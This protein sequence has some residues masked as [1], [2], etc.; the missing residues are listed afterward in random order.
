M[1]GIPLIRLAIVIGIFLIALIPLWKLTAQK[2][3]PK[4]AAPVASEIAKIIPTQIDVTGAP[5]ANH[6]SILHLG[7]TVWQ[8]TGDK[9]S[10]T[11]ALPE[12]SFDLRVQATWA[13]NETRENALRVRVSRDDIPLADATFW[14]QTQ[15][16]DVLTIPAN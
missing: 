7:K 4:P 12:K 1:R 6:F 3:L 15:V 13:N 5:S 16:D 10:T 11:L 8:G 9:V 14:G 2:E